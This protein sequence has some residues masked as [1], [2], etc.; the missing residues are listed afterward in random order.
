CTEWNEFKQLDLPRVKNLMKQA[1]IVDGRN[2]YEPQ[3]MYDLGFQYR[4]V[5]RAA[6]LT[7][8]H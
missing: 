7:N 1:I 4:A 6:A 3:S 2:I 5:G 8:G